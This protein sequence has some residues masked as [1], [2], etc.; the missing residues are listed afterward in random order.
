MSNAHS[1]AGVYVTERDLSQRIAA[2]STS[3]GA[4]V[5]ASKKGPVMKRTLVTSVRQFLETFGEPD[6]SVSYMHYAALTFLEQSSRLYVTRVAKTDALTA[7]A[8]LS[9]DDINAATPILKLTNFDDGSNQ[10][11]GIN[12]PF[13]TVGFDANQVGVDHILGFFCAVNPGEWNNS[14]FIKV[15]PSNNLGV[16]L[17]DDPYVFV[18]D[19][20][21]N[22]TNN[23]QLPVESFLVSRDYRVDG[24]QRQMN[25][26]DVI[27]SKSNLI[28]YVANPYA[29]PTLKFLT[30]ASEF[31]DGATNGTTPESGL[32]I[33]GWDLYKDPEV[34]DVNILINGGYTSVPVQLHMDL[35]A[36]TRMDAVAILDMP[37]DQQQVGDA[38]DYVA[39][40]LNLNSS[41]S[42][43][44]SPDLL[45]YD[46]YNDRPL[47]VPPSGFV[48]AAYALTDTKAAAWVAPAGMD[49]GDL[50][51]R[52]VRYIYNQGD[53]DALDAVH[54]NPIRSIPGKGYKIWG[55]DTLQSKASALSNVN[56][57]RLLNFLEKSISIAALYSVFD[58]NDTILWEKL[59]E[60]CNRFL[61]PIKD[62][63]GLY[64]YETVCDATNNKPE[65]IANGDVILDVYVDPV[66][67][68]KRIHLNAI[69]TRTGAVFQE[70]A[71]ARQNSS[72]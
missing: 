64:W 28:R 26:S 9:T 23:R 56:V 46:K 51:V 48:A 55:A 21:L 60:M 43:I 68:A 22:Y 47:Y 30:E 53:R 52:G 58:P 1:S 5:G 10:P 25:I 72:N 32:L 61:K 50:N 18:V 34:V 59:T 15:R 14:I 24:F 62:G 16:A 49:R 29:V 17:P 2:A 19:V 67:P 44:Y 13:N 31:L 54:I 20:F 70:V 27:N 12:D 66:L 3:I 33:Q 57:R 63:R 42:T 7:G 38:M 36:Q 6:P 71:S 35:L 39:N 40:T 37:F 45:Y 41:Y 65:T 4:I 69:I 8:Y 11:L